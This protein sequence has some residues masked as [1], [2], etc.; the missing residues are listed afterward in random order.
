M[1]TPD[2]VEL[3]ALLGKGVSAAAIAMTLAW[4]TI[5]WLLPNVQSKQTKHLVSF[6]LGI[7]AVVAMQEAHF[8]HFGMDHA[9]KD[10]HNW[11]AAVMFGVLAG[12]LT[13]VFHKQVISR[14]APALKKKGRK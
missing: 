10:V 7:G 5:E 2:Q 4:L 13:P 6:A 11:I 14:F 9:G 1:G 3:V 12:G 8:I